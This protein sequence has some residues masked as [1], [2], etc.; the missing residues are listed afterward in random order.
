MAGRVLAHAVK[1]IA[2]NLGGLISTRLLTPMLFAA[3][4]ACNGGTCGPCTILRNFDC[5]DLC[6]A[7]ESDCSL[8]SALSP[9]P[10]IRTQ[11]RIHFDLHPLAACC[12]SEFAL[13][14]E[15]PAKFETLRA[16]T[17]R[18]GFPTGSPFG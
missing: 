2:N 15:L 14:L 5:R 3:Q 6:M 17:W 8:H 4:G 18:R 10:R 11:I 16:A 13:A 12:Q 1:T 7:V 9:R